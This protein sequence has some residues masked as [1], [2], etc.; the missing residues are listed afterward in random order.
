MSC[1]IY[2]IQSSKLICLFLILVFCDK[3]KTKTLVKDLTHGS[4]HVNVFDMCSI[5]HH[6]YLNIKRDINVQKVKVT[7]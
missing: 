5:F 6:S 1:L 3:I 7:K 2:Y 4:L